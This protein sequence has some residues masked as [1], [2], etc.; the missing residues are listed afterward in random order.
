MDEDD[1]KEWFLI[2]AISYLTANFVLVGAWRA[3]GGHLDLRARGRD[4]D[5]LDL[6]AVVKAARRSQQDSSRPRRSRP[7]R[8]TACTRSATCRRAR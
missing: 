4:V 3:G 7:T 2:V 5:L 8:L 1:W 6:R